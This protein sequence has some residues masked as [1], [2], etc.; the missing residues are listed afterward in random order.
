MK[1]N[2]DQHISELL[3]DYDC[4]VVPQL[5]GFVTNY[6]PAKQDIQSGIMHPAGKDIRFNKNLTKSDGLL[7][8]A[9]AESQHMSFEDASAALKTEVEAYWQKLNGGE[10]LKLKKIGVLYIDDHRK[11][12]FEPATD[13][14]YL[15][16]AFG[17][18]SFILPP[19]LEVKKHIAEP[20]QERLVEETPVIA[21]RSTVR[22]KGIYWVAA[23]TLLPF[24]AMSIYV[25]L[26]S[27]FKSPTQLTVAEL[28]PFHVTSNIPSEY[29]ARSEESDVISIDETES[30]YPA[31]TLVFPYSFEESRI[32]STGVWIDLS[33][34]EKPTPVTSSTA[35]KYHIIG[36]CFGEKA[37]A[38]KFV[39]RLK[40]RGYQA[41]VLDLHKNLYR[42][43]IESFNNYDKALATL[44]EFRNDGTFP[45]AWLLKKPVS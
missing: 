16:A 40:Y 39:E 43:K 38:D 31:S 11:L 25:G 44:G 2:L 42:V 12:R 22:Q 18:E 13:Q 4:V 14:N 24:M 7:E 3:H 37:N 45:N 41:S 20:I 6:R 15:K 10:K 1:L 17:F 28:N 9:F 26:T 27:N 30:A 21:L 19:P 32:D 33:M 23:A 5:G 29:T 36:G 34:K 8:K 35:G